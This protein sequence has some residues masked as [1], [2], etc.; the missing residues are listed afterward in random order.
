MAF[1]KN[2]LGFTLV[3]MMVVIG[4]LS[5][6][7]VGL[8]AIFVSAIQIQRYVASAY[9]LLDQSSYIM[10]YMTRAIR[11]AKK[12]LE[13]NCITQYNSYGYY[14]EINDSGIKFTNK[15]EDGDCIGF[16]LDNTDKR[17]KQ[18][19]KESGGGQAV[20]SP[21]TSSAMEVSAFNVILAGESQETDQEQPKA[22]IYLEIKVKGAGSQP[23]IKLQTTVSMRDLDIAPSL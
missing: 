20:I 3:E 16:F 1:Q 6:V 14:D 11:L 22:T 23:S 8:I 7:I 10:E 12:D 19:K 18:Y 21:L 17:L 2:N 9:Q 4:V 13:G 15:N 5:I